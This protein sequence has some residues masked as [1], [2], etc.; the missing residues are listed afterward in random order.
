MTTIP[1]DRFDADFERE[2]GK[3]AIPVCTPACVTKKDE[4]PA[5]RSDFT[6]DNETR[7]V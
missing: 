3:P 5:D 1:Y 4:V 6:R 2:F 7:G